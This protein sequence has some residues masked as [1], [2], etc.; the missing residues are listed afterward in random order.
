MQSFLL[1]ELLTRS[2][3][4]VLVLGCL[5]HLITFCFL[6]ASVLKH[7]RMPVNALGITDNAGTDH[8]QLIKRLRSAQSVHEVLLKSIDSMLTL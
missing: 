4:L 2:Y 1:L 7:T 8:E 3:I 6:T 5:A